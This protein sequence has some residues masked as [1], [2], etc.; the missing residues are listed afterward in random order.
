MNVKEFI[1]KIEQK[2]AKVLTVEEAKKLKGKTI[3]W[4]YFGY[5]S[6]DNTVQ[7]MVIGNIVSSL[8]F[9]E[10]ETMAGYNSRADYWKSYMTE[11]QLKSEEHTLILLDQFGKHKYIYAYLESPFFKEPTFTCTDS[12]REV[13]YLV[14]G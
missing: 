3:A 2:E 1:E 12:D 8:E 11:K 9:H 4:M 6:N 7:E 5:Q 13:Y 10:K 14:M